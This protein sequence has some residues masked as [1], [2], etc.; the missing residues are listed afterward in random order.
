M[1]SQPRRRRLEVEH[2][3]DVTVVNFVD[4][5]ILDEQNIQIIGE[6]LLS[7]VKEEGLRKLLLNFG[8]VEYLS[9]AAL[10]KL[11]TLNKELQKESGRLILCNIRPEIL[12]VFELTRLDKFFNIKKEEQE[13][14][15]AF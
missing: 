6:Q 10:G 15:Q 14:L 2:I 8:N 13:A 4:R 1:S 11:I 12:E 3:G 9:S 5:K 7:L